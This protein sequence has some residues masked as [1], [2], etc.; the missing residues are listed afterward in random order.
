M[1]PSRTNLE[2]LLAP[3]SV[4]VV[5]ASVSPEKAGHQALLALQH[6]PGQVFPIN[7]KG[8]EVLGRRAFP[9]LRALP[10]PVDLV[11]F[12]VPASGCVEALREAID[13][14]CASGLILGG[15]FGETGG[16]GA[17]IQAEIEAMC[18]RSSFRLL[19]P[20]TAGFLNREVPITASFLLGADR[21]PAGEI[22]VVAQSAGIN[23]TLGFLLAKLGYG[24]SC[25]VGL[26]NAVNV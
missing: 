4:A 20:N 18:A 13:S 16:A 22:A 15:G 23:L 3:A 14:K 11:I 6:F 1:E 5:G 19:G 2:R 25:A 24:V 21:I 17:A 8:G 9:S 7:P 10:A 12:A 26:G